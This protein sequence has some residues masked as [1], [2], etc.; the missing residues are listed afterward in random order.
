MITYPSTESG[1]S[2][3]VGSS[4]RASPTPSE[5]GFWL[6]SGGGDLVQSGGD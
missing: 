3:G 2:I 1:L 6:S 5:G 4:A